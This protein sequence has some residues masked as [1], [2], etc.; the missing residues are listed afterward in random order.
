VFDI[1]HEREGKTSQ[2]LVG[3]NEGKEHSGDI[4]INAMMISK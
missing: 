4:E 3:K 1:A 2:M